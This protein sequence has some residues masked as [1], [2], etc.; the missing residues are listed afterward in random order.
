M[1]QRPGQMPDQDMATNK[2]IHK[3]LRRNLSE[4]LRKCRLLLG[5]F[6]A[7]LNIIQQT[8]A[9]HFREIR[10][11]RVLRVDPILHAQLGPDA[12]LA[13]SESPGQ[14]RPTK[15]SSTS[16]FLRHMKRMLVR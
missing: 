6:L 5:V 15:Q 8:S 2:H 1:P 11:I 12:P 7:K 14:R 13:I 9:A 16:L 3:K 4:A 10:V